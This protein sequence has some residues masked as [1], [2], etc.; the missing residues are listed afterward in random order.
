MLYR[1]LTSQIQEKW[2][3]YSNMNDYVKQTN[4]SKVQKTVRSETWRSETEGKSYTLKIETL[5][6]S[7]QNA[8]SSLSPLGWEHS[9]LKSDTQAGEISLSEKLIKSRQ[10]SLQILTRSFS[11]WHGHTDHTAPKSNNVQLLSMQSFQLP[12]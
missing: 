8:S 7:I 1:H 4:K 11:Q 9:L 5:S 3:K 10:E 12:F 2:I 6:R